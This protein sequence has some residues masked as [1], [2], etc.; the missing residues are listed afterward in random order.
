MAVPSR[1]RNSG[2]DFP[3]EAPEQS[4]LVDAE[5]FDG[6][7][8]RNHAAVVALELV[9]D[10]MLKV[11]IGSTMPLF[12]GMENHAVLLCGR[13]ERDGVVRYFVHDDSNGP[14]LAIDGISSCRATH[15]AGR[16]ANPGNDSRKTR[17][18][19]WIRPAHAVPAEG[20]AQGA[21]VLGR[22]VEP[23]MKR[24]DR[25][26]RYIFTA[27]PPRAILAP[28]TATHQAVLWARGLEKA[29]SQLVDDGGPEK[30]PHLVPAWSRLRTVL[31]MGIDYKRARCL[32]AGAKSDAARTFAALHLPE[33]I[34]LVEAVDAAGHVVWENAYDASSGEPAR[35]ILAG[36]DRSGWSNRRHKP[37][38]ASAQRFKRWESTQSS[39]SI[40][41]RFPNRVGKVETH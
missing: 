9:L 8:F 18:C 20:S 30:R 21:S 2:R 4:D 33:W 14:Y 5:P 41:W 11:Y 35:M 32:Q 37:G 22:A 28:W 10:H 26:A 25:A 17:T 7:Y 31:V 19:R 1:R 16:A 13:S 24:M 3:D 12:L 36:S 29:E 6:E 38:R 40:P 27:T 23:D 15:C 34:V 39:G